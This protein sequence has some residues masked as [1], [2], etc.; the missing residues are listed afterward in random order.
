MQKKARKI[1]AISKSLV[2]EI[3]LIILNVLVIFALIAFAGFLYLMAKTPLGDSLYTRAISQTSIVYDRTGEHVLYEIYGEENR[4]II[5]HEE[6]PNTIRIATVATEDDY[7]YQHHGLD[8][9]AILRALIKNIKNKSAGQGAST[10]TQQLARNVYLNR[11]KTIQRKVLE[12]IYAIKIDKKYDKDQILDAYLNQVPYGSNIYGIETASENFFGKPA[13]ELT[14]DEAAMLAAF[15]KAPT[16]YSPYGNHR[17]ALIKRQK[18]ILKKIATLQLTDTKTVLDALKADTAK[19]IIPLTQP[20]EAPHFVFYVKDQ[21]EQKYGRQII[22]E[23]GLKIYTTLDY[24]KQKLAEQIIQESAA[25]NLKKYGA[26]NAALVA[27]DPQN[28][29]ILAMVGSVD[30]FNESADGQVNVTIRARQPGSSFKP[31]V[32]AKAFEDGYQPEMMILDAQTD[33]GPDGSGK[34]YVPKNYDGKFHGIISMRQALAMSLNVPAIKTLRAV[35]IDDAIEMAH[36]LGITTLNDRQRYGLS[37][38]IGGGEVTLLDET[39]GFSVF[40]NDGKRNPVD[41]ILKIVDSKNNIIQANEPKNM[42]VLDPQIARKINSIL[43]DNSARVPIFGP[44]NLLFIPGRTV[45]AKTG[46]TQEF[47]DAWTVGFTPYLAVGVWAGN[48]DNRPMRA[49]AAGSFVAAPIWNKFMSQAIQ[50]YPDV[51]F[52]PYDKSDGNTI[53]RVA[54]VFQQLKITYYKITSGKKISEKKAK[55]MDPDKVRM[56][57]ETITYEEDK[58]PVEGRPVF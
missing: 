5:S 26:S 22:E 28:G 57:V 48:N 40:A 31:F 37:L 52:A 1:A 42:P 10:I 38:V 49:G 12:A 24:D 23:G 27:L 34:N 4:K 50:E 29:Q 54:G 36:R 53:P 9:K 39:S 18:E 44:N 30:F 46:T 8:F 45:A 20:V 3:S 35:S 21:L 55:K 51:A 19:K 56:K 13:K 43:S 7:F 17:D 41:P 47:R 16:Y 58:S 25:Y 11:D 14:L 15:T 32:Y 2:K 33:F 6:I